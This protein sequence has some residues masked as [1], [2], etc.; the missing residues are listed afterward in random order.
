MA[1]IVTSTLRIVS[2]HF[3]TN[4]R[5]ALA[6][7]IFV[8]AGVLVLFIVNLIFTQRMLRAAHPHFGWHV[9]FSWFFKVLYALVLL[10]IIA[11]IVVV[12]QMFY[13]LNTNTR[14][15]DRDIQLYGSTYFAFVSFLP[16]PFVVGGLLIP[17]KQK[18]DKFGTGR[19]RT[20]VAVLLSSSTLLCFGATYRVG[21]LYRTPVSRMQPMPQYF[22]KGAFYFVNF[23]VE[24]LVVYLY[25]LLRVDKRFH[26]PNGASGPGSYASVV[27]DV[28]KAKSI[29]SID[30][31]EKGKCRKSDEGE[32]EDVGAGSVNPSVVN[33]AT[34]EDKEKGDEEAL[35]MP[36]KDV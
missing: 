18:L 11:V 7:Q 3:N 6:A 10:S 2:I 28:E 14:R 34:E 4:I 32:R 23:T 26:V 5:L 20:K 33:L 9:V 31:E 24:I 21:T 16:I 17:R 35:E 25:A 36:V 19:W 30:D 1:R 15:I 27:E 12:V 8:S 29:H 22:S 13:S